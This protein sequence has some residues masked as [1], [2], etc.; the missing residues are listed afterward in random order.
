MPSLRTAAI[1]H[2]A[3]GKTTASFHL[4]RW[5]GDASVGKDAE[6]LS[7]LAEADQPNAEADILR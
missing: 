1:V 7:L 4:F 5:R 3:N 2:T 6:K